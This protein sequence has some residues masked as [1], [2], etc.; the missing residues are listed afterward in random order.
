VGHVV[1]QVHHVRNACIRSRGAQ[2]NGHSGMGTSKRG[3]RWDVLHVCEAPGAPR[4]G[5]LARQQRR[6]VE[7]AQR[8]G[9]CTKLLSASS[10]VNCTYQARCLQSIRSTKMLAIQ[11]YNHKLPHR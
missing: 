2:W 1:R 8:N 11:R 4:Q 10:A 5:C 9:M 3:F 6:R 7:A